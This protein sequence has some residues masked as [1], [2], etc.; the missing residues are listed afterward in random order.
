MRNTA[1]SPYRR[2]RARLDHLAEGHASDS[3]LHPQHVAAAIDRLAAADAV[4]TADVGTPSIWAA[5]YLHMNGR[6]RLIGSRSP[7]PPGCSARGWTRQ[8]SSR[9]RC[10]RQCYQEQ[11][12]G[13]WSM[14]SV[15]EVLAGYGSLQAGQEAFYKELHRHPELSHQE[16]R[17]AQRVAGQLKE[18]GFTVPYG[19]R[20]HGGGGRPVQ[21]ARTSRPAQATA[22][23]AP[24]AAALS[25][26]PGSMPQSA[27]V[28][29]ECCAIA[30]Y[31]QP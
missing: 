6:R 20:R 15:D 19:H 22:R 16:H 29:P 5:R 8:A 21:W 2:A 1:S 23:P 26:R 12:K 4:F 9:M 25:A 27:Y 30:D 28:Q 14:S 3:P 11:G 10:E 18:Y 13:R 7:G 24:P 17:T 31:V